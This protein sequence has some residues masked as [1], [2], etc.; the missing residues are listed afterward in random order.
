M[1]VDISGSPVIIWLYTLGLLLA[2]SM[3]FPAIQAMQKGEQRDSNSLRLTHF[4]TVT[5]NQVQKLQNRLWIM[6]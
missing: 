2:P 3:I 5:F 6:H 1:C 4:N